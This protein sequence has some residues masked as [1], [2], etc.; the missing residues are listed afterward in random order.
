MPYTDTYA[1]LFPVLGLL[2]AW[3]DGLESAGALR[4]RRRCAARWAGAV[5][6]S[7]YILLIAALLLGTIRFLFRK[8]KRRPLET[9]F[10][11]SLPPLS[12]AFCPVWRWKKAPSSC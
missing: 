7:A 11:A 2:T 4:V 9:G 6:P 8:E 10:C 5:K 3:T 1:C 12:W